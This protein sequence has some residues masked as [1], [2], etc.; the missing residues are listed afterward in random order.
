M[1]K[2]YTLLGIFSLFSAQAFSASKCEINVDFVT[3]AKEKQQVIPASKDV[4]IYIKQMLAVHSS[5]GVKIASNAIC[6]KLS[7]ASYTGS[8]QE[9]QSFISSA[10][11]G[12]LKANYTDL[13]ITMVGEDDKVYQGK[14]AHKEYI[15]TGSVPGN[16]QHIYN[17]AVLDKSNN[18]VYTMS[19]SGNERAVREVKSEFSRL[20]KS[21]KL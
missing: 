16:K 2:F 21:F 1:R 20:I 14:L 9:W 19:V 3:N 15:F 8:E 10:V 5:S 11:N 4:S 12:L 6:Q 17:L 13:Q 18:T 7:G